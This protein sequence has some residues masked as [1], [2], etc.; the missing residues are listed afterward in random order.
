MARTVE[1]HVSALSRRLD[2]ATWYR[3][4][5][6]VACV[7]QGTCHHQGR[8]ADWCTLELGNTIQIDHDLWL[9][10]LNIRSRM[11]NPSLRVPKLSTQLWITNVSISSSGGFNAAGI[12]S[13]GRLFAE[14]AFPP[15]H[16]IRSLIPAILSQLGTGLSRPWDVS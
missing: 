16:G 14:S 6:A 8:G 7:V 3:D 1:K 2:S 10:S 5:I 12:E 9:D 11:R 4:S 13:S 15:N